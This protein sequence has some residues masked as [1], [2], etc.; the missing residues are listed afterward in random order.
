MAQSGC[1]MSDSFYAFVG[2][3]DALMTW[4]E[5]QSQHCIE[6]GIEQYFPKK[7]KK[8]LPVSCDFYDLRC[9]LEFFEE[10]PILSRAGRRLLDLN[11]W[12]N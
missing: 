10:Y 3:Q 4:T 12:L 8:I 6:Q 7:N 11:R 2:Q 1:A 5:K 9:V